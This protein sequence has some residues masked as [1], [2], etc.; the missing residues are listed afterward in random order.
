MHISLDQKTALVTSA[1]AGLGFAIAQGLAEAG[2]KVFITGRQTEKVDQAVTQLK[3]Q[4][5]NAEITGLAGT[6]ASAEGCSQ[7]IAAL[8]QVDI[9]INNLGIYGRCE[10]S[11]IS[12]H[13]WF[14]FFEA[15]IFSV[16]RLS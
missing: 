2:A 15:N 12:D 1:T 11:Q 8:P 4:F 7:S 16:V 3:H 13:Q 10:F 5:P 14:E 6:A 9:L